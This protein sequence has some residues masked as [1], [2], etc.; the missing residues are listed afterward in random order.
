MAEAALRRAAR[1]GDGWFPP[2][3]PLPVFTSAQARLAELAAEYGRPA[4]AV[5]TSLIT[6]I[7]GDPDLPGRDGLTRRLSDPDGVFGIPADQ[8][9]AALHAGPPGEIAEL[10]AEH[11]RR[12]AERV[13]ISVA[14]GD[15][16]R[17]A[18]L[19]AEARDL[20]GQPV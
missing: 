12:G 2:P 1:Y 6:A 5:T 14:A 11:F 15:W 8:V 4:P 16:F 17:Q 19:A 18:E 7:A 13:V 20:L 3:V 10:L 9:P